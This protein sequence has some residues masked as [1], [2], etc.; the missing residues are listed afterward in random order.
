MSDPEIEQLKAEL[1]QALNKA[2]AHINEAS[3]QRVRDY[4]RAVLAARKLLSNRNATS[5]ALRN[6]IH[7]VT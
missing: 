4:K 5:H 1:K 2:P 3:V 6:A 7:Q